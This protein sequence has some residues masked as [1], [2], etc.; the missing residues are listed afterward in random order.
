MTSGPDITVDQPAGGSGGGSPALADAVALPETIPPG[1]PAMPGSYG[2]G[3]GRIW[4]RS[5]RI[6]VPASFLAVLP[7]LAVH[8]GT[9]L[10][11]LGVFAFMAVHNRQILLTFEDQDPWHLLARLDGNWYL[12][13]A[14]HGYRHALG[15]TPAGTNLVFFP[16]YPKLIQVLAA[17]TGMTPF[18]A[19]LFIT[20]VA[21]LAASW[22]IYLIGRDWRDGKTGVMLVALWSA[23]PASVVLSMVYTEPLFTAFAAWALVAAARRRWL[24]AGL[25]CALAG[26]TRSAAIALVAAIWVAVAVAV[27]RQLLARRR[28]EGPRLSR[29]E[30]AR[31]AACVAIAP[32]G[33]LWFWGWLWQVVGRAD[34]WFWMERDG[35]D[36]HLSYGPALFGKIAALASGP[37]EFVPTATVIVLCVAVVLWLLMLL[38]RPPVPAAVYATVVL[39]MSA[40]AMNFLTCE[41]RFLLPAFP[42][43]LVPASE[44]AKWP[45]R[46]LIVVLPALALGSAWF[47]SYLLLFWPRAF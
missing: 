31:L 43:L 8:A 3:S 21:G 26:L 29:S 13:I 27:A 24:T 16:L 44:L 19:G 4:W 46:S 17:V 22:A 45:M 41:P 18:G 2:P 36:M 14:E 35:W 10:I 6:R 1:G 28:G 32:L 47:G 42:L 30:T 23:E 11:T 34:A 7:A 5:L 37:H 15:P 20:A 40:G 12:G 39:A 9:R 25:L 38:H 33:L